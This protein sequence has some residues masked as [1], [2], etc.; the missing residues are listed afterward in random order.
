VLRE[1]SDASADKAFA[2]FLRPR[3]AQ[4]LNDDYYK[5]DLAWVDLNNPI[6]LG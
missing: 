6:R 5:S 1:A 4:L 3:A 2:N